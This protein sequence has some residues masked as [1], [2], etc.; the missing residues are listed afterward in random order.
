MK[1][2]FIERYRSCFEVGKMCRALKVTRS[3]YYRWRNNPMSRRDKEN[4]ELLREIREVHKMIRFTYGSPRIHAELRDRGYFIG[5]NR[6]ARLMRINKIRAKTKRRFKII[7][8]SKHKYS[9]S[10]N[11]LKDIE[12]V[13]PNQ[14]WVSDIT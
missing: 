14:V 9:L 6:V 4:K 12:I 5:R 3:G 11:L 7:T 8:H 1:Y 10:P 2:E 13:K